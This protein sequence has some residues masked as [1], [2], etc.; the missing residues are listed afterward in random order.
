MLQ[1]I[2]YGRLRPDG[3]FHP[4]FSFLNGGVSIVFASRSFERVVC[5][6]V[7]GS[8]SSIPCSIFL[9]WPTR[10]FVGLGQ[11]KRRSPIAMSW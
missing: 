9:W 8:L 7:E 10:A 5:L 2:L 6:L 3:A 1:G 4:R 11:D